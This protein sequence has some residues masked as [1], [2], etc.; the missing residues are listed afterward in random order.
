MDLVGSRKTAIH[1]LLGDLLSRG[2]DPFNIIY[3]YY[4]QT[5]CE[6]GLSAME[7]SHRRTISDLEEKHK[8]E[9]ER[10]LIDKEQ[11]LAEETQVSKL[12]LA[13]SL[14][15]LISLSLPLHLFTSLPMKERNPRTRIAYHMQHCHCCMRHL[16]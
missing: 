15:R 11:A 5:L 8:R 9:I 10:L 6:K 12:N 13:V 3:D 1:Y 7:S 16:S 2:D 4:L 14:L